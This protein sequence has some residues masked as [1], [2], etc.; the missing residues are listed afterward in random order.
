MAPA[1]ATTNSPLPIRSSKQQYVYATGGRGTT[2]RNPAGG[3]IPP[4][5]CGEKKP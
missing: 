2:P 5:P 4:D 3:R 1:T